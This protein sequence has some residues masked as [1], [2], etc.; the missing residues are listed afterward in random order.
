[1]PTSSPTISD[2]FA[3]SGH[4]APH[5]TAGS[6]DRPG[7]GSAG[8]RSR[9]ASPL[10]RPPG[11]ARPR[12]AARRS[13]HSSRAQPHLDAV[14]RVEHRALRA[15]SCRSPRSAT[16]AARPSA[17]AERGSSAMAARA[18]RPGRG[19]HGRGQLVRAEPA[20]HRHRRPPPR[21]APRRRAAG[22]PRRA[23]AG[24][25]ACTRVKGRRSS[26]W[27]TTRS[28]KLAYQLGPPDL[29]Q[30]LHA[31]PR[32]ARGSR[33]K[34]FAPGAMPEAARMA[35]LTQRGSRRAPRPRSAAK[36]LGRQEPVSRER[37]ARDH[38]RRRR[39]SARRHPQRAPEAASHPAADAR[40]RRTRW[41]VMIG[42]FSARSSTRG[43]RAGR[44][45]STAEAPRAAKVLIPRR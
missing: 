43:R 1:M 4:R 5:R 2:R 22:P 45:E 32:H 29:R 41:P 12:A 38:R 17:G 9:P 13:S 36:P 42:A 20:D 10:G 26:T 6:E 16:P 27:S 35:R 40:R 19:A 44:G 28:G 34:R 24:G 15:G 37:A 7:P 31:A 33:R 18:T 21:G 3:S 25:P 39:R 8:R 11:R 23:S 14:H 30:R